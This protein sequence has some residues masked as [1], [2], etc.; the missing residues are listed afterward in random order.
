MTDDIKNNT[1]TDNNVN[2]IFTD[3]EG[4]WLEY[5]R[6]HEYKDSMLEILGEALEEVINDCESIGDK[7]QKA[8]SERDDMKKCAK[9]LFEELRTVVYAPDYDVHYLELLLEEYREKVYD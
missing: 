1:N 2:N 9:R 3:P 8:I 7:Y 6:T 4:K 5:T